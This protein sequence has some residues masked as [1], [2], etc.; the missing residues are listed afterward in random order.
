MNSEIFR[1]GQRDFV[2]GI[3]VAVLGAVLATLA[4]WVNAPGFDFATFQWGEIL[5]IATS[6]A[7]FYLSKNFLSTSDDKVLGKI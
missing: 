4:Q 6:A 2:K 7:I 5:K 3:V 1:L